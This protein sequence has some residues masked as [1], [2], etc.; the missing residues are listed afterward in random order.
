[1]NRDDFKKTCLDILGEGTEYSLPMLDRFVFATFEAQ[2]LQN[3][4][5]DDAAAT[6]KHTNKAGH[7]NEASSPKVRMWVL[8]SQ[9]ANK[10][11]QL[12]GLIPTAKVGRPAKI[13]KKKGFDLSNKMKVA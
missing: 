8:Y 13:E 7:T 1:M 6:I 12:L 3:E 4:I 2:R 9:E 11:G 10:L 5:A